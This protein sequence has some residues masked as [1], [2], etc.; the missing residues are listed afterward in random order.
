M[1][2]LF[3]ERSVEILADVLEKT[4]G[5]LTGLNV[6]RYRIDHIDDIH[7]IDSLINERLLQLEKDTHETFR[8]SAVALYFLRNHTR[9]ALLADIERILD[10]LRTQYRLTLEQPERLTDIS[11]ALEIDRGRVEECLSYLRAE[12]GIS[13]GGTVDLRD[14]DA[15]IMPTE[16]LFRFAR[17]EDLLSERARGWFPDSRPSESKPTHGNVET[18]AAKREVILGAALW[19]INNSPSKCR[20]GDRLSGER[21]V[22]QIEE[23]M[24]R[25]WPDENKAPAHRT[26]VDLINKH[27]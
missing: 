17:F 16:S 10:H 11:V 6:K 1:H 8:I 18:N 3:D 4:H 24:N 2:N 5:S 25:W 23:H 12:G 22:A 21:I 26:M 9:D 19:V 14:P 7:R 13:M 20:R 27:L 15:C